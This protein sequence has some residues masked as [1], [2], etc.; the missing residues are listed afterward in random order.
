MPDSGLSLPVKQ[1]N[2]FCDGS[3]FNSHTLFK[4]NSTTLQLIAYY[5]ELEVVN[6]IG[7]YV[8]HHKLG[9]MFYFLAN[10]R[11]QYRSTLKSIQLVAVG[12]YEDIVKYAT[13]E[14]LRPFVKDVKKLYC[15][16]ISVDIGGTN[17]VLFG[18]LVAF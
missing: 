16:G 11:P 2:D 8:K 7:S 1:M 14:F 15:D 17:K 5:D 12:K 9:C 10:I 18:A 3:L 13:D 6:P 4:S